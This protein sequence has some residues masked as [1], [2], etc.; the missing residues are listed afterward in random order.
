MPRFFFNLHDDGMLIDEE[1]AELP[2]ADAA[3]SLAVRVARELASQQVLEGRL[4]LSHSVEVEDQDR[5]S[6]LVLPFG[7]AVT[8]E[9]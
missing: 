6:I 9:E 1:G 8:V 5:R 3:R 2:T 7:D 4:V